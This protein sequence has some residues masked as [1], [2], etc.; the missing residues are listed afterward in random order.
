MKKGYRMMTCLALVTIWA[1]SGCSQFR[2]DDQG[3]FVL[4]HLPQVGEDC[5][6]MMQAAFQWRFDP[7][8]LPKMPGAIE[9]HVSKALVFV[10]DKFVPRPD[11]YSSKLRIRMHTVAILPSGQQIEEDSVETV[12]GIWNRQKFQ[13]IDF[14]DDLSV[15]T[16]E[17]G[18]A[19]IYDNLL[20]TQ[21]K[22]S[23]LF[24]LHEASSLIVLLISIPINTAGMVDLQYWQK[25][26]NQALKRQDLQDQP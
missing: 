8:R 15:A 3:N 5:A 7:H 9:F 21:P 14:N 11:S 26:H 4:N 10:S 22:G 6:P 2:T 19:E 12:D 18:T 16:D 24:D 23:Y 13:I 20:L 17:A 1:T 25:M